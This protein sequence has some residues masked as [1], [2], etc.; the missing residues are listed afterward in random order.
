MNYLGY[1]EQGGVRYF[2]NRP[3][4]DVAE[5]PGTM[6]HRILKRV[7][8]TPVS[9]AE[10]AEI[11]KGPRAQVGHAL[12]RL[13]ERGFVKRKKINGRWHYWRERG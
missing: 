8:D 3:I 2:N 13:A 7:G 5:K 11:V 9:A 6:I 4:P 12:N 1:Y 10:M